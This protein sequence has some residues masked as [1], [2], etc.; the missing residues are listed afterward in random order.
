MGN[1]RALM[2]YINFPSA[3]IQDN[4]KAHWLCISKITVE[5]GNVKITVLIVCNSVSSF[6]IKLLINR[7]TVNQ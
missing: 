4:D 1:A 3:K 6:G 2:V 7:S 5:A